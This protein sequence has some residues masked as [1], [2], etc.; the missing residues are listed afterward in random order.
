MTEVY[1]YHLTSSRL[2]QALSKL[3]EKVRAS[4]WRALIRSINTG[5]LDRLDAHL[6]QYSEDNFLAHGKS[7]GDYDKDQ[8]ILLTTDFDNTNNAEILFLMDQAK[9]DP[10]EVAKFTRVCLIFDGMDPEELNSARIEW[11]NC[12]QAGIPAQYWAQDDGRWIKKAETV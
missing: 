4:K 3:L 9:T 6:W 7:G 1:F 12:S 11:K 8:P 10:T 2:E 5:S